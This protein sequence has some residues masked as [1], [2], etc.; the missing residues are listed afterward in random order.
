MNANS[1]F[2]RECKRR[3]GHARRGIFRVQARGGSEPPEPLVEM[4]AFLSLVSG[5][6]ADPPIGMF[7][8]RAPAVALPPA[9]ATSIAPR[10]LGSVWPGYRRALPQVETLSNS[11]ASATSSHPAQHTRT[12]A[13]RLR[14]ATV[15]RRGVSSRHNNAHAPP[16]TVVGSTGSPSTK[17]PRAAPTTGCARSD[18]ARRG[19]VCDARPCGG[20][21]VS[22]RA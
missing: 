10:L 18:T 14:A 2:G 5:V 22:P 4:T 17:L 9:R 1:T 19:T 16:I 6:G 3:S 11:S 12:Y 13:A 8:R 7:L 21:R 20:Q 15:D